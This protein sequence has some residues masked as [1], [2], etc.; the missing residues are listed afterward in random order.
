M[1]EFSTLDAQSELASLVQVA[2]NEFDQT[3]HEIAFQA[4]QIANG[5]QDL[6]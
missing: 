5:N 1:N 4:S 6:P 2:P 3:V